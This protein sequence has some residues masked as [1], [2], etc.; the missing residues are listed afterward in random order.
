MKGEVTQVI[1][2]SPRNIEDKLFLVH[3]DERDN[4]CDDW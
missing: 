1:K 3:Y 2:T 4:Y